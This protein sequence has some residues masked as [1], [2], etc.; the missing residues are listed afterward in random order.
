[1]TDQVTDG[2]LARAVAILA[3]GG[4]IG[5]PTETVYGL[6]ADAAHAAAVASIYRI[7]GRPADHPLIVHVASLAVAAQWGEW[8][9]SAQR[10]ASAFWPGP[11]TLVLKRRHDA[12]PYA[13]AGQDTVALRMAAHPVFQRLMQA[14]A[15]VGITG[16]AAP[17]ANRFGRI[18]PSCAAHVRSGL[19]QA[20]PL[21]LDGGAASVGVESTIVDLSRG[22]PVLLR[23]GGIGLQALTDCLGQPVRLADTLASADVDA[24]R[25]P[26]A[27]PSHYAPSVPLRL[28]PVGVL[29]ERLRQRAEALAHA[30]ATGTSASG[31]TGADWSGLRLAV[32]SP[33]P[34]VPQTGLVWRRQPDDA[35]EAAR[36]LYAA[37]HQLDA[38]AADCILVAQPPDTPA[39]R[40][41][42]D[43]LQRA[44]AAA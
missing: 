3:A 2:D 22:T 19:G 25:V 1:M 10:L 40:A 29:D 38:L 23:P 28:L 26:G 8:T 30:G 42:R 18:S 5:L 14:L 41:V 39:W 35:A 31:E 6:A 9:P 11:L 37:L 36:Q 20:V 12:P 27:L 21:V 32:W 43:R 16:L 13:S 44:A 15:V 24:P 33:R 17:S 34:P 7:K 4:V